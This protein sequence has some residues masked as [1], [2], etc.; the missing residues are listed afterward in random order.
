MASPAHDMIEGFK[1]AGDIISFG[2]TVATL[3][4][5]LPSIAGVLT[6]VWTLIRIYETETV[7]AMLG[8][9]KTD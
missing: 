5:W 2:V 4:S 9:A 6:I 7:Q 3:V 1:P 8:K